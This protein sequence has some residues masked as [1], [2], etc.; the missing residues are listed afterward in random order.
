M[1]SFININFPYKNVTSDLFLVL[2]LYLLF[3][4]IIDSKR[5]LCQRGIFWSPT[6]AGTSK[7]VPPMTLDLSPTPQGKECNN[8]AAYG[9]E[10]DG[11]SLTLHFQ[12]HLFANDFINN[13][14]YDRNTL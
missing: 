10:I 6:H 13:E 1:I 4:E 14:G 2:L 12:S 3:P 7:K 9:E 5:S 8:L 11:N